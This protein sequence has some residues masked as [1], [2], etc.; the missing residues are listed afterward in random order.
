ME[1]RSYVLKMALFA[2]GLSG[3]VA[4][5]ILSTL[6]TYFLGNSVFQWTIIISIMM[7]SMGLGS[8]ISRIF[9]NKLLQK[10]IYIEFSLS[11]IVSFAS[12]LAY[13]AAAYTDYESIIIYSL[14]IIIGIFI[15]MEIPL[16]IRLNHEF[17]ILCINVS[18]VIEMDYYGS[19]IGGFIYAF[20][21]LPYLGLTYTPFVLGT[22]NFLVA[23]MLL[24]LLWSQLAKK[25]KIILRIFTLAVV[26]LLFSGFF[27]AKPIIYWGEQQKY[28]DKVIY[29]E[30]TRYQKIV[31]TQWQNIYWLY[32][33]G[34]QQLSTLDEELYHEPLV[35]PAMQLSKS[36][37]DILDDLGEVAE[38]IGT[39][40]ALHKISQ[41]K[42]LYLPIAKE[43]Y[44]MLEGKDPLESLKD[45]LSS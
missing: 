29:D 18:S 16:V 21:G 1:L 38:G 32:I 10:F 34:N 17:E 13:I 30:Q 35:H 27:L 14:S 40:Y 15:G 24:Y 44:S 7:F 8:R 23:L 12:L 6:A 26:V 41:Q 19:L 11:L 39:A 37:Q 36:Q 45:L 4:E 25:T 2:T 20:V 9:I 42:D 43:V 5:Y 22:I 31:I 3:I 28:R 33:N